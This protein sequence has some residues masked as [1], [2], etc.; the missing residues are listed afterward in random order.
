MIEIFVYSFFI[1]F[2]FTPF[3]VFFI[4]QQNNS[5]ICYSKEH[6]FGL[7][8]LS[9]VA[10]FVNFFFPLNIFINTF[11]III[12]III[13]LIFRKHYLNLIF[14]KF[15]LFGAILLALLLTES[16]VYRPD[17]GL[18]HLPFVGILNSEK[19]IIGLSNLHSRYGHVSIIQYLSA[20][21]NN[22]LLNNN[23]INFPAG[24]IAISVIINFVK[25][26]YNYNQ[27]KKYNFHFFFLLSIVIYIFYKM[28]RYSEYGN[29][30]PAHFL[31]F[32][33][34]S[35]VILYNKKVDISSF[36]NN[37]AIIFFIVINKTILITTILVG[38][39]LLTK[40]NIALFVKSKKFYFLSLF[41]F[42]WILKNILT[43]GCALY[44]LGF[45][46]IDELKWVN[47]N[48]VEQISEDAEA[49]SKGISDLNQM[50]KNRYLNYKEFNENFNWLDAWSKKHLNVILKILTPYSILLSLLIFCLIYKSSKNKNKIE[51]KYV[52]LFI[53]ILFC[54]TIWFL[55][56]P[57]Y[58]YGYSLI[59]VLISLIFSFILIKFKA[60]EKRMKII[61][62]TI[63]II[64]VSIFISKNVY[65]TY[66]ND[67][68]YNNY[69]WPKYYSMDGK[70][71]LTKY[72]SNKLD[73][74]IILS[75]IKGYCMYIKKLCTHYGIDENLKLKIT[76]NY[77]VIYKKK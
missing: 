65:R 31:L 49:W 28:N 37:L 5:I 51:K 74:Q 34:I 21:S 32:F 72:R 35:E 73:D 40:K 38:T 54:A 48:N 43:S 53:I 12:S 13:I 60:D 58:R 56:A 75:P 30:A 71:K 77:K 52:Y 11:I 64:G 16:E 14:L 4:H 41:L 67:N 45:T 36:G 59:I 7:I 20:I 9:F 39:L 61:S 76:N 57:L 18:Y 55:K 25:H 29:D 27:K 23:G 24:L 6:I 46:C 3:G 15:C 26:I 8:F 63:L 22:I 1:I 62:N 47:K 10:V 50:E 70:N 42:F 17:A 33:L 66:M 68:N 44:P 19:I 2:L 69:P